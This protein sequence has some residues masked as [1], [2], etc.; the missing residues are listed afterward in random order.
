MNAKYIPLQDPFRYQWF[1]FLNQHARDDK[2]SRRAKIDAFKKLLGQA[3]QWAGGTLP[4]PEIPLK[5]F[6]SPRISHRLAFR[7]WQKINGILREL[8]ARTLLDCLYIQVGQT[9]RG[10]ASLQTF[11]QLTPYALST[12]KSNSDLEAYL[13]EAFLG[14]STCLGAILGEEELPPDWPEIARDILHQEEPDFKKLY[15]SEKIQETA[16]SVAG[17]I[18][19]LVTEGEKEIMILLYPR[20]QENEIS[21]FIYFLAPQLWLNRLKYRLIHERYYNTLYPSTQKQER[22][23]DDLLKQGLKTRLKLKKLEDLSTEISRCQAY[24]IE[25]ISM[26]EEA[27]ESLRVSLRNMHLLLEDPI[28]EAQDRERA[29]VL[30]DDMELFLEQ[31]ETDLR[32]WKITRQQSELALQNLLTVVGVRE[33]QWERWITRIL[34]F[35]AAIGFAQVFP[36]SPIPWVSDTCWKIGFIVLG[37]VVVL[38]ASLL[39]GR[40]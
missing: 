19:L 17:G 6:Q 1:F 14:E 35:F 32:F 31:V 23:L 8:E 7:P 36:N 11:T 38:L 3:W 34:L 10:E 33:V 12:N 4:L 39:P 29:R 15:N 40:R 30:W 22:E 37:G 13:Q 2:T 16:L 21:R 28:W 5:F 18:A 20:K 27:Q 9:S 26:I 25:S 24:F